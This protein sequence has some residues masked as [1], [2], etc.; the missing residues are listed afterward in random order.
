MNNEKIKSLTF[1]FTFNQSRCLSFSKLTREKTFQTFLFHRTLKT[2]RKEEI[3]CVS[4]AVLEVTNEMAK[5]VPNSPEPAVKEQ[6]KKGNKS[7]K[8][9][10]VVNP[11]KAKTGSRAASRA[12][13]RNAMSR[14][15]SNVS[16][17]SKK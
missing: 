14:Q 3:F 7:G 10:T 12:A 8:S 6:Q 13:S 2:Q 17:K 9:A 15:K 1:F 4:K 5:M 16:G 11:A